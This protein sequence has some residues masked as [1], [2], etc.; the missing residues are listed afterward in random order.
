MGKKTYTGFSESGEKQIRQIVNSA[1]TAITLAFASHLK[2]NDS[3]LFATWFGAGNRGRV[4]DVLHL[5]NY[6]MTNGS[7]VI[8]YTAVGYCAGGST[9]AVA[10][11]PVHGWGQATVAQART[12]ASQFTLDICPRLM[13][14]MAFSGSGNQSQV[15]TLIHEISHLLGNTD[16]EIDPDTNNVAYGSAAAKTL[17]LNHPNQAINNVEN[18]GFYVSSYIRR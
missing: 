6:A 14:V 1:S 10:Y 12:P 17:A 9:N 8:N 11:P 2:E 7:I 4:K 18:Y 3:D 13:N 15:G 5:I 16:D